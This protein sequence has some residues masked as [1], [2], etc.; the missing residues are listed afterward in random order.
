MMLMG[1]GAEY[2]PPANEI[3]HSAVVV[4]RIIFCA[5]HGLPAVWCARILFNN[6]VVVRLPFGEMFSEAIQRHS[7][8]QAQDAARLR[9]RSF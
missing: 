3:Q 8:A 9:K 2:L 7:Q 4:K 5:S 1:N 6:T